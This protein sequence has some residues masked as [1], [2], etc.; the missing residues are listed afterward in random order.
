MKIVKAIAWIM[1]AGVP[2]SL[3]I[4]YVRE[5]L[6]VDSCLDSGG[7]F[8][9]LRMIC[10]REVSHAFIPYSQRHGGRITVAVLTTLV[11]A[12]YLIITRRKARIE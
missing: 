7:S 9:Y 12:L 3:A 4:S 8:D 6:L 2:L 11:A 10:E 5:S 1:L